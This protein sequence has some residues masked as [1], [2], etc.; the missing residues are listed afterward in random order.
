MSLPVKSLFKK[1]LLKRF[2]H[3]CL[4]FSYPESPNL[5][6]SPKSIPLDTHP[7]FSSR[8]HLLQLKRTR[9]QFAT[10]FLA[11]SC[12]AFLLAVGEDEPI[13]PSPTVVDGLQERFGACNGRALRGLDAHVARMTRPSDTQKEE[14]VF[15]QDKRKAVEFRQQRGEPS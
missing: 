9:Q 8:P 1:L 14:A 2:N 3:A 15:L 5:T 7:V 12:V 6:K 11:C 10:E 13:S 4:C